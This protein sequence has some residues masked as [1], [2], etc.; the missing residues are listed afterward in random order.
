MVYQA[1]ISVFMMLRFCLVQLRQAVLA[2]AAHHVKARGV[3]LVGVIGS[4]PQIVFREASAL[5]RPLAAFDLSSR[6]IV[7]MTAVSP[8]TATAIETVLAMSR[9]VMDCRRNADL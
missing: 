9:R 7:T 5:L 6:I 4:Y 3:P 1:T 2:L 8:M